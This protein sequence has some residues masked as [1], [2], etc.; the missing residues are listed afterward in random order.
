MLLRD[1]PTRQ[2]VSSP[3]GAAPGAAASDLRARI[4]RRLLE[5]ID[6]AS[7]DALDPERVKVEIAALVERIVANESLVINDNEHRLL[8]RDMQDEM[9]GLGPLELLLADPGISG[10]LVNGCRPIQIERA[11]RFEDSGIA[12]ADRRHLM[13]VV[14]KIIGSTGRRID[15]QHP[16]A[17]ARLPDGSVVQ[18]IIPPVAV[19]GPLLSIRRGTAPLQMRELVEHYR[20][21]SP[22]MALLLEG[23]VRARANILVCGP[24]DSGKTT[25]LNA[26]AAAIA[27]GERIVTIEE[28][29]E[30]RLRQP[31]LVRLETR[32]P[33]SAGHGEIG[34]HVLLRNALRLRPQRLVVGEL[35]GG[36]SLDLLQAMSAGQAGS[37]AALRAGS[38]QE[39]LERLENM[40]GMASHDLPP[41]A[42]RRQI[43]AAMPVLVHVARL[44]DGQRKVLS[45]QEV[46]GIGNGEIER[47]EI[48]RFQQTAIGADGTVHGYSA[49][50]GVRPRFAGLLASQG[51]ALPDDLF[52][53]AQRFS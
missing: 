33:D 16:M 17:E 42:A 49:A 31:Q 24:G 51:M 27:P 32:P 10:I 28:A 40:I 41:Q 19:D 22:A 50:T 2:P 14:D 20:S 25:L 12:F 46:T 47:Q 45:L 38:P 4:R 37:L 23:L 11:G 53:P 39:A 44:I 18:A 52:D 26:L 3:A 34:P 8:I 43:A 13:H 9:L 29:A 6:P 48:F 7:L 1:R 21:L 5:H 30:L 15:E 35:H 36:E